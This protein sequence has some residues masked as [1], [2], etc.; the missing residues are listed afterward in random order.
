MSKLVQFTDVYFPDLNSNSYENLNRMKSYSNVCP[1]VTFN[2][3]D[4]GF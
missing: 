2:A 1:K 3:N 4:Q